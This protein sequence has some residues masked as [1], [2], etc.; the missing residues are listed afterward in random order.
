MWLLI[1]HNNTF[2]EIL[3]VMARKQNASNTLVRNLGM[4]YY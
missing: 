1:W 4:S 3:N 2:I